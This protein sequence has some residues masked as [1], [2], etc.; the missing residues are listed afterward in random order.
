MKKRVLNL[1]FLSCILVFSPI[2][3]YCTAEAKDVK[4]DYKDVDA[5]DIV[6]TE[7]T[8]GM[9]EEGKHIILAVEKLEAYGDV[10]CNVTEGDIEISA[11]LTD[12]DGVLKILSDDENFDKIKETL[13]DKCSYLVITI[14]DDSTE[15]SKIVVSGLKLYLDRTL[16]NGSYA[17]KDI[18]TGSGL[19]ENTSSSKDEY[20]KNGTF[21][22]EPIVVDSSYVEVITAP[23]DQD[24]YTSV[25]KI[26]IPVGA[27]QV[28]VG[29]NTINLDVPAYINSS[30]YTMLPTRAIAEALGAKVEWNDEAQS[31]SIFSGRRII[32]MN[33]GKTTMYINGT[34]VPMN[35]APE[36]K[37]GRTFI[38][39]RDLA[40]ALSIKN[41]EWSEKT[42]TVVLN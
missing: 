7:A 34:P 14:E 21:K 16:P 41:I 3:P 25:L 35:T 30:G 33:I 9:F 42:N 4:I 5:D 6:I 19:W 18:Y 26:T 40:N 32:S 28:T 10:I 24:D 27:N 36:I 1:L 22:Y 11:E 37:D 39:V 38:P 12:M 17:L 20:D 23:R 2:S 29:V 15:A 8:D 13:S 31:V